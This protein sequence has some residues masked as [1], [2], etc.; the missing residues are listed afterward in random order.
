MESTHSE[1][2][3]MWMEHL[4]FNGWE[5]KDKDNDN[6]YRKEKKVHIDEIPFL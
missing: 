1:I 5:I 4:K 2:Y 6:N 3:R